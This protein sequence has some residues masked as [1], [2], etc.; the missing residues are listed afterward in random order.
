M[1]LNHNVANSCTQKYTFIKFILWAQFRIQQGRG[2]RS[3]PSSI[4]KSSTAYHLP[5]LKDVTTRLSSVTYF[6]KIDLKRRNIKYQWLKKISIRPPLSH[7]SDYLNIVVCHLS[8][9]KLL[10]HSRG[11]WTKYFP[12]LNS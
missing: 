12:K 8:L 10:L 11:V 1:K 9:K 3:A 7:H 2:G 4:A 6:T 5:Q